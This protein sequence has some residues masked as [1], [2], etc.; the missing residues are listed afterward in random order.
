MLSL[1]ACGDK[2][3]TRVERV[4][5]PVRQ[6]VDIPAYLV[7]PLEVA[8]L[9]KPGQGNPPAA[10]CPVDGKPT[11]CASEVIDYVHT[12]LLPALHQAQCDRALLRCIDQHREKPTDAVPCIAAQ[13][14]AACAIAPRGLQ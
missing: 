4:E 5:V 13:A 7:E 2:F 1:T 10:S 14:R 8:P 11:L 3:L 6:Y 9:P 12:V